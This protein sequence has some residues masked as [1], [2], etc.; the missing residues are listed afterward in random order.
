MNLQSL[1]T[2]VLNSGRLSALTTLQ[3]EV[4]TVGNSLRLRSL[5]DPKNSREVETTQRLQRLRRQ[6]EVAARKAKNDNKKKKSQQAA[7]LKQNERAQRLKIEMQE[8]ESKKMVKLHA[9]R[10]TQ[11]EM[12]AKR[13]FQLHS[14]REALKQTETELQGMGKGF[15]TCNETDSDKA[16]QTFILRYLPFTPFA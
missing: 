13:L 6:Q 14:A 10:K 9:L 4:N 8:T 5:R 12:L 7:R 3:Q 16:F 15:P 1:K 2:C 11:E